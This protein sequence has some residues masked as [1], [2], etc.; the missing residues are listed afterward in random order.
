VR[1]V[2]SLPAKY[3]PFFGRQQELAEIGM[4]ISNQACHLLTLAGP[5]GIGKTR[6]ALAVAEQHADD[7]SDG[8]FFVSFLGVE[9]GSDLASVVADALH[10]SFH[11]TQD[12]LKLLLERLNEKQLLLVI[13]NVEQLLDEVGKDSL[14]Q[15]LTGLHQ[16][17]PK[18]ML[19]VTSRTVTHLQEEWVFRVHGLPVMP[20][21]HGETSEAV[22]FFV[23]R[24]QRTGVDLTSSQERDAIERICRHVDGHPLALELAASWTDTLSCSDIADELGQTV[25][26]LVSRHSDVPQYHMSITAVF[27][28]SWVGLSKEERTVQRRLAVFPGGCTLEAAK[29][30]AGATL[31]ILAHLI[32]RSMLGRT[33]NGRYELHELLRQY[34]AEQLDAIPAEREEVIDQHAEYYLVLVNKLLPELQGSRQKEARQVLN[35]DIQNIMAA[36]HRAVAQLQAKLLM[37]AT[38]GLIEYCEL[39]GRFLDCL[40]LFRLATDRYYENSDVHCHAH[41][42]IGEG[43]CTMRVGHVAEANA[44]LERSVKD[45]RFRTEPPNP[46]LPLALLWLGHSCVLQG[47][48]DVAREALQEAADLYTVIQDTWG[49]GYAHN[50]LGT[51]LSY[52][53]ALTEAERHFEQ[54]EQLLRSLGEQRQFTFCVWG[55]GRIALEQGKYARARQFLD[56]TLTIRRDLDDLWGVGYSTRELGYVA[57]A[58]GDY[59]DAK[60]YL[61][62]SLDAFKAT[63]AHGNTVF[64]LD[65]LGT[66]LRLQGDYR[67]AESYHRQALAVSQE[68]HELRGEALSRLNLG[69]LAM[70]KRDLE[71]AEEFLR[72]SL[73][74]FSQIGHQI[75]VATVSTSLGALFGRQLG[76]RVEAGKY[77]CD[78]LDIGTELSITP[79]L[80]ETFL[81]LAIII[82]SQTR[83]S[84]R[85]RRIGS[86]F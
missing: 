4:L 9:S 5:G 85:T 61:L 22:D 37:E 11:G 50:M 68:V 66:V 80:L 47:R 16:A 84:N 27:D 55:R 56:E 34:A 82:L 51:T 60:A 52:Q 58:Q 6:L 48:Y 63:G 72:N 14:I 43:M 76:R 46:S 36:W 35:A 30:V 32:D 15:L 69:R 33:E 40:S 81:E 20:K 74:I 79:V 45:L 62:E 73:E 39:S 64:P 10:F 44:I 25:G 86:S 28:R 42:Q 8:A 29:S 59:T 19:I 49:L 77:F 17:S 23:Q 1:V 21:E 38:G 13:D 3:N 70:L 83:Y 54:G 18:S 2:I 71:N 26:F 75:G 12:P 7:Y 78:A 57:I 41:L 31:P 65:A 53:G 67:Q 24:A